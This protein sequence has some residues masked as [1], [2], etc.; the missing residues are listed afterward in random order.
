MSFCFQ[1]AAGELFFLYPIEKTVNLQIASPK[2]FHRHVILTD[3]YQSGLNAVLFQNTIFYSYLD[4]EGMLLVRST[5][6]KLPLFKKAAVKTQVFAPKL[7]CLYEELLLLYLQDS[8]SDSSLALSFPLKEDTEKKLLELQPAPDRIAFC[9][10][11]Q[12]ALSPSEPVFLMVR[13]DTPSDYHMYSLTKDF[14]LQ[15]RVSVKEAQYEQLLEENETLKNQ[16]D[17]A[18]TQYRELMEVAYQYREEARKWYQKF[19]RR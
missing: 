16:L 8:D 10:E 7:V 17:Q 11:P 15:E 6:Q 4:A 5:D 9:H 12:D 1:S 14:A 2:G 3:D 13:A 18:G 19:I